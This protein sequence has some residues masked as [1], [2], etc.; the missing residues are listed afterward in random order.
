MLS[1][2]N[3]LYPVAGIGNKFWGFFAD[4][5]HGSIRQKEAMDCIHRPQAAQHVGFE[6]IVLIVYTVTI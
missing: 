1:F 4:F 3:V 6:V 2:K 5:A